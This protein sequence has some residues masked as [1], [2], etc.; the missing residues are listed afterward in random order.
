MKQSPD[1]AIW[2]IINDRAAVTIRRV[3]QAC[4]DAGLK[5]SLLWWEY[6]GPSARK[7]S[8]YPI[9]G[10]GFHR[11]DVR[12]DFGPVRYPNPAV[13]PLLRR[14]VQQELSRLGPK[15]LVTQLDHTLAD[16]VL[17]HSARRAG[18]PGV[19]LQ[20]GMANVPKSP[21]RTEG[22][23]RRWRARWGD[24][25][26]AF[27]VLRSM[28]HP[29]LNACAPYTRAQYAFVWGEAMKRFLISLGR[30]EGTTVVTGS[31]AFDHM[32]AQRALAPAQRRTVL[33]VHQ[34]TERT[35]GEKL[36]HYEQVM[37]IVVRDLEC[38]LVFKL[39]PGQ[40]AEAGE[41]RRLAEKVGCTE[42]QFNL[43]DKGNAVD[44]LDQASVVVVASSTTAYHAA[45]AGVPLVVIDYLLDDV[46][47]D[48]GETGGAIVVREPD[49]LRAGLD[50]AQNDPTCREALHSGAGRMLVDH[51]TVLDGGA[52]KRIATLLGRIVEGG[53]A[54]PRD[55]SG[56]GPC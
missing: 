19:V 49:G 46:R 4:V 24:Q 25:R 44:L 42:A 54:A 6:R 56:L 30:P 3:A 8:D 36:A 47:F 15:C 9:D 14:K 13:L 20:E 52:A 2:G 26:A 29:L 39:H 37:R 21:M 27:R 5:T 51:L 43:V 7:P 12:H 17:Q 1:V 23:R 11:M 45:V 40:E 48:I 34:P 31:P 18:I 22:D 28:P 16:R 50:Q 35:L 10:L 38:R 55:V 32:K 41:V 33:Y 53:G